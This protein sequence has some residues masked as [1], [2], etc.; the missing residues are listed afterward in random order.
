M[1]DIAKKCTDISI[2]DLSFQ[3]R[4]NCWMLSFMHHKVIVDNV[5][6]LADAL[7]IKRMLFLTIKSFLQTLLLARRLNTLGNISMLSRARMCPH[8][9][10]Q[11]VKLT[12]FFWCCTEVNI[13][14]G[15]S[16]SDYSV[17]IGYSFT[18]FISL[19]I[20]NNCCNLFQYLKKYRR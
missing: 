12:S 15:E 18:C 8:H 11:A 16:A 7:V 4:R 14:S 10:L 2:F 20:S 5:Q 6:G 9:L 3:M 19:R 17:K 13:F 1:C